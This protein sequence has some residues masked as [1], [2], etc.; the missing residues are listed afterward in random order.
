MFKTSPR[1]ACLPP[2]GREKGI[3]HVIVFPC[4]LF[5]TQR[6]YE[7]MRGLQ[8]WLRWTFWASFPTLTARAPRDKHGGLSLKGILPPRMVSLANGRK[9]VSVAPSLHALFFFFLPA[10]GAG[11]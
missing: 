8:P 7:S 9:G 5:R 10:L 2:E 1:F 4:P 6:I 3:D 11:P